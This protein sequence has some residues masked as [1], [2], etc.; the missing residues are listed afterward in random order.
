[1]MTLPTLTAPVTLTEVAPAEAEAAS[2]VSAGAWLDTRGRLI[3]VPASAVRFVIPYM[4]SW[5][6]LW[7]TAF[8]LA[9]FWP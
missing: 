2:V 7:S 3:H 4:E 9:M 1:M 5:P 6:P 8:T